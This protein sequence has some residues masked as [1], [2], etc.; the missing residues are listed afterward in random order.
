MPSEEYAT[1]KKKD[2]KASKLIKLFVKLAVT[3]LCFWYISRKIDFSQAFEALKRA[4]WLLL[5][6]STLLYIFSK[7][8]GA[9]RLNIYF[10]DRKVVATRCTKATP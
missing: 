1:A 6:L 9:F 2:S 4:N 3:A 10:E 8:I 7:I 5:V